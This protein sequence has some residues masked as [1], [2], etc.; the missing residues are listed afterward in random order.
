MLPS[1]N[2]NEMCS[3]MFFRSRYFKGLYLFSDETFCTPSQMMVEKGL[4]FSAE[5]LCLRQGVAT[6]VV[7]VGV[8]WP[9]LE[10]DSWDVQAGVPVQSRPSLVDSDGLLDSP[11]GHVVFLVQYLGLFQAA[12]VA[13]I[14][15]MFTHRCSRVS[16]C[17]VFF[18][19]LVPRLLFVSPMY[20][21]S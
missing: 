12:L 1:W 17:G 2:T 16:A 3:S 8:T 4:E 14:V 10:D 6:T 18:V 5:S 9:Q 15:Q 20:V 13:R 7:A 19:Y 11:P 21:L